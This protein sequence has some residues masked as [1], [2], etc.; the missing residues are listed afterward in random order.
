MCGQHVTAKEEIIRR[1]KSSGE[2]FSIFRRIVV[3]SS[4][5][6]NSLLGLLDPEGITIFRNVG[7]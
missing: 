4:S 6:L 1:S 3:S 2:Y 7:N 5:R